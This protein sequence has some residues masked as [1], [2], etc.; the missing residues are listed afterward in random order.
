MS[1]ISHILLVVDE[2][3]ESRKSKGESVGL[4]IIN[5]SNCVESQ[6]PEF[7]I[8]GWGKNPLLLFFSIRLA[9]E[10]YGAAVS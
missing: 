3:I 6:R 4:R 8:W 9:L 10:N 2:N 1:Q 5:L 7:S